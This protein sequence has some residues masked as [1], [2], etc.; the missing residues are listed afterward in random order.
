MHSL[1]KLANMRHIDKQ[2]IIDQLITT[3]GICEADAL[4]MINTAID[5]NILTS[6]K[7][8]R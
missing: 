6:E 2:D 8:Q 1:I 3:L 7:S 4:S 5:N